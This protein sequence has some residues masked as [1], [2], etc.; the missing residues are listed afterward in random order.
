M[1]YKEVADMLTKMRD[2]GRLRKK[3]IMPKYP[4]K[5]DL[6]P[7][8]PKYKP[9]T[10]QSYMGKSS[11]YQHIVHFKYR[12]LKDQIIHRN[13]ERICLWLV[14][15]IAREFHHFMGSLRREVLT[16]LPRG[17]LTSQSKLTHSIQTRREWIYS[18]L[19][20]QVESIG[21][22]MQRTHLSKISSRH[23]QSQSQ[24]RE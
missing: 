15:T 17:R 3:R 10:F 2:E 19:H 12:C 18:R 6:V 5:M 11:A 24:T 4:P 8:P 14:Q 20:K 23:V 21:V 22:Q 13:P 9:P 1:T 7:Y 16:A